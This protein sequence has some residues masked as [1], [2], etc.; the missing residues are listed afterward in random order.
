MIIL[1]VASPAIPHLCRVQREKY[2]KLSNH[3]NLT[4]HRYFSK[5]RDCAWS[6]IQFVYM[7]MSYVYIIKSQKTQRIYIGY[8]A[9]L[10]RRIGEHNSD[11]VF[12]TKNRGPWR[13]IYYEAFASNYDARVR[14]K[15]L[16]YH[17]K[18]LGLLKRRIKNSMELKA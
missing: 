3:D 1:G 16:K 18:A 2:L 13:L 7:S 17:G 4:S 5:V 10:K 6:G 12:S 11:K 14:E 9:D 15:K 8:S